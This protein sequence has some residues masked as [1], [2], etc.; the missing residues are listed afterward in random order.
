MSI[1]LY[2]CECLP[3]HSMGGFTCGQYLSVY[4]YAVSC[5]AVM[6]GEELVGVVT[7]LHAHKPGLV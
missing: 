3:A 5:Q 6:G 7:L 1:Y 4:L 2:T